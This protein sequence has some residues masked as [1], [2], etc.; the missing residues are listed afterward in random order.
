MYQIKTSNLSLLAL[1]LAVALQVHAKLPAVQVERLG[2]DLTPVGAE[3][4]GNKD[5]TIP[6]WDGGIVTAP[7]GFDAARGWADP[8]KADKPLY[9]ITGANAEQYKD[10][11]APGQLA[12]LKLISGVQAGGLSDSPFGRLASV[13]L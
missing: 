13:G 1:L 6:S 5:G 4:A 2:K 10:K 3:K 12:L 11:L 8:Y 7:A 9:T